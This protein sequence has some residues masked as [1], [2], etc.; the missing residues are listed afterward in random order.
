MTADG[1]NIHWYTDAGLTELVFTGSIFYSE[2]SLPGTYTYYATQNNNGCESEGLM[3]TLTIYETPSV[4]FMP[5]DSV[6]LS[7][8]SFELENGEPAGGSYFGDGVEEGF[9]T[10]AIAGVGIHNLGYVFEDENMCADTAYQTITVLALD[11]VSLDEFASVCKNTDSFELSGG[12]PEGGTY[13]G[14]G[15]IDNM[16]YPE[17]AGSGD[18]QIIYTIIS[19]NGCPSPATQTITVFDIP[20]VN[21]GNDST[22]CGDADITLNATIPNGSSYLWSPGGATTASI[23]VDSTGVGFDSQE[24]SVIATDNNTCS[25]TDATTITFINCTGIRDIDGLESVSLYPNPNDGTFNFGIESSVSV[26][27]NIKIFDA[28][29]NKH[30]ELD[31][32]EVV[33]SYSS[34]ISLTDANP[35]IYFMSIENEEG[36]FIKKFLVR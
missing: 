14:T 15:I 24:Y 27:V 25:N 4:T 35:G 28:V 17:E 13:S 9:F 1:E 3:L 33:N 6:C 21:I 29:G 2:D 18:H 5:L 31:N 30:L 36:T 22:I 11:N 32:V 34:R 26:T 19:E 7:A 12:T 8:E 23:T 10:A 20:D 16:F